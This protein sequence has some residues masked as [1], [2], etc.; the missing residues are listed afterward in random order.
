MDWQTLWDTFAD[1]LPSYT[2]EFIKASTFIGLGLQV[3]HDFSYN[4]F[5]EGLHFFITILP[6]NVRDKNSTRISQRNQFAKDVKG[7]FLSPY[8]K[9][10]Q[11][12][13]FTRGKGVTI[14]KAWLI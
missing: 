13:A 7:L 6:L 11:N 4:R 5:A 8:L 1:V 9:P 14:N 3:C 10:I 2:R 12:F